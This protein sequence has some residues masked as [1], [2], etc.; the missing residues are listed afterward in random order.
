[1]INAKAYED[2]VCWRYVQCIERYTYRYLFELL[3][4]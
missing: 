4:H 3:T 2:K 1:M